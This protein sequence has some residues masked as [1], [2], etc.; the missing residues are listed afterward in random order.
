MKY[1]TDAGTPVSVGAVV[2]CAGK[3]E[4]TGLPYNKVLHQIGQKTVLE[5]VI[6][7]FIEA[8]IQ[9]ITV[10]AA[11]C[12]IERI[13]E[14]TSPYPSVSIVLGGA[15]RAQSVL[16][17][18]NAITCDIVAIHDGARPF[19]TQE[20]IARTVSSAI[21]YGSGIASV[22]STDTVKSVDD[23]GTVHSLPRASIFNMQTPQT[24]R[25]S[26]IL[27][28]YNSVT[29][30][31][32]DDA[33]VYEHCGYSPRLVEGDYA[34]IKITTASDLLRVLPHDCRIGVGFDVHRL[35][36]S[37]KLVLGGVEI[38]FER[39]LDGHSDADVLVHAIMDALLSAADCPDIGVLFPDTDSKY[40]GIS[41]M[42]LLDEV[43]KTVR[44]K[45]FE[46]CS[47]SAVIA[48]QRPKLAPV[49]KDIRNSLARAIGI[50]IE[51]INI[52]A[53]TT[54]RLGLIGSGDAIAANASCIMTWSGK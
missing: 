25:R 41:S 33:E 1:K 42:K 19:V 37:R 23:D 11:E 3:G 26:E 36:P 38:D 12:D 4:R 7:R 28:A 29:G 31:F 2:L 9:D 35:V 40:L 21:A 27:E 30:E 20:V 52:S 53:T 43:V 14:L 47:I 15:T 44:Q 54:E 16:N 46:I 8:D 39:G 24:F 10:V 32:T 49:I 22:P 13:K 5:L 34:N 18:L 45:K 51:R 50:G 48:A 6:D 17:G